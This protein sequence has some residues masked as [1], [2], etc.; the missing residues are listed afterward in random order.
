[1][2]SLD[3]IAAE[4]S[5]AVHLDQGERLSLQLRCAAVLIAL[6]ATVEIPTDKLLT[7]E[8]AAPRLRCSRTTVYSLLKQGKLRYTTRGE[9][10]KLIAESEIDA[11][12]ARNMKRG[13]RPVLEAMRAQVRSIR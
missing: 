9:R 7:P 8:E 11:Y 6:G 12:H 10:G 13:E 3:E 5:R 2:T 1:M 4:P